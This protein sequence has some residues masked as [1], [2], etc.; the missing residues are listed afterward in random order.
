M[1][2][3]PSS[4]AKDAAL[5]HIPF[6]LCLQARNTTFFNNLDFVNVSDDVIERLFVSDRTR[7]K[8]NNN[9]PYPPLAL[10]RTA[11]QIRDFYKLGAGMRKNG[12]EASRPKKID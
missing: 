4:D 8:M 1:S 9:I 11:T 3:H 6:L 5:Y 12:T 2:R 10:R 7:E